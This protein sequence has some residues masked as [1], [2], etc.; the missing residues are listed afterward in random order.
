MLALPL[1]AL[2]IGCL[3]PR[4]GADGAASPSDL[5]AAGGSGAGKGG[6]Q[7]QGPDLRRVAGDRLGTRAFAQGP[8]E[9]RHRVFILSSAIHTDIALPAEA[10]V[11]ASFGFLSAA[12]LPIDRQDVGA[13]VVGWGGRDFYIGTPRWSDIR[14]G[15][16]LRAFTGDSAVLHVDLAGEIDAA[17]P[18]V[19]AVDLGDAGRVRQ[20]GGN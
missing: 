1:L 13:I 19:R 12:G 18:G 11:L 5:A 10:S 6:G 7:T 16:V 2:A 4:A 17:A 3:V 8:P 14:P 9:A 20:R 15:P